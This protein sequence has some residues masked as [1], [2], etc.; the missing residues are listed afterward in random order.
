MRVGIRGLAVLCAFDWMRGADAGVR[1]RYLEYATEGCAE[2][3]NHYVAIGVFDVFCPNG[4]RCIW[5]RD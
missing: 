2:V 1:V 3:F 5:L 4:N